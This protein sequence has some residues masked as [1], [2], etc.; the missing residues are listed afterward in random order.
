MGQAANRPVSTFTTLLAIINTARI[1]AG[2]FEIYARQSRGC[3]RLSFVVRPRPDTEKEEKAS[4][5]DKR[6]HRPLSDSIF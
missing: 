3:S 5:A 4:I 1:D 2:V 6:T